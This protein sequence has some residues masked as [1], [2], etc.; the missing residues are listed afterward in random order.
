M[1]DKI[2]KELFEGTDSGAKFSD[3]RK[4]RFAL[5]R[6]WDSSKPYAMIIGLNPSIAN[7]TRAD[8]TLTRCINLAKILGYGGVCMT[9]LF[10]Y[11]NTYPNEMKKQDNPIGK[12]NDDWLKKYAEYADIVIAAWGNDGAFK[13]RS[14]EVKKLITNLYYLQL[15]QTGEPT[16]PRCFSYDLKP[17]KFN[18]N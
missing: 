3:C 15:N 6:I 13:N 10:A 4:Y 17:Q 18:N 5:W 11:V 12:D 7:E 9:N 14:S 1:K 2:Y 16:H 8:H